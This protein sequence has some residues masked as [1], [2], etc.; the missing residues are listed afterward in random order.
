M[1]TRN[2]DNVLASWIASRGAIF[3]DRKMSEEQ[4]SSGTI[5]GIKSIDGTLYTIS[6][7]DTKSLLYGAGSDTDT[8]QNNNRTTL[9][10]G[11]GTD[12]ETYNDYKLDLVTTLTAYAARQ[13]AF[14]VTANSSLKAIVTK[15]FVNNTETDITVNEAGLVVPVKGYRSSSTSSGTLATGYALIYRKKYDT[16]IVVSANGGMVSIVLDV[17]IPLWNRPS[18]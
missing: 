4:W 15:V 12:E 8:S 17:D 9:L 3:S 7:T 1:L 18:E 5:L 14:S 2:F 16:P 13:T 11:S 10:V 6:G